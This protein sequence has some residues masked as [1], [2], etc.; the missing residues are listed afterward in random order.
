MTST[1]L[2]TPPQLSSA[3][4]SL[5]RRAIDSSAARKP[6]GARELASALELLSQESIAQGFTAEQMV[7]AL[8][9]AWYTAGRV[10]RVSQGPDRDYYA[11]LGECL[12]I[13]FGEKR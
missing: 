7:V 11:A 4:T 10:S 13:Y 8:R 12:A 6:E 1:L 5:L 9:S 3:T 2:S